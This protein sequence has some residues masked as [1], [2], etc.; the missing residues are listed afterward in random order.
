MCTIASI[1]WMRN[2][3][4]RNMWWWFS[5]HEFF[6][7]AGGIDSTPGF[8]NSPRMKANRL[9]IGRLPILM[10]QNQIETVFSKL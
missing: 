8:Y 4:I 9:F 2:M 7:E 5:R 1:L 6:E 10:T 3:A